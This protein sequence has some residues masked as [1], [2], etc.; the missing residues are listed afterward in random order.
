MTRSKKLKESKGRKKIQDGKF[1][2]MAAPVI[3]CCL[4]SCYCKRGS[5][6][7][8][9]GGFLVI[10]EEGHCDGSFEGEGWKWTWT[11]AEQFGRSGEVRACLKGDSLSIS[12][13]FWGRGGDVDVFEVKSGVHLTL[14]TI[15][16]G[17]SPAPS[18]LV[19]P[20]FISLPPTICCFHAPRAFPC[21]L[22]TSHL[23]IIIN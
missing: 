15:R 22:P 16:R 11:P 7:V 23:N 6:S 17:S 8:S 19:P 13:S 4:C 1:S 3:Y 12:L 9:E 21:Y 18:F 2:D 10:S 5:V 20:I 14:L